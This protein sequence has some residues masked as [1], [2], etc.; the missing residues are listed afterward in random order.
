MRQGQAGEGRVGGVWVG[1]KCGLEEEEEREEGQPGM[2]LATCLGSQ[3]GAG[4]GQH[5]EALSLE[6]KAK[7]WFLREAA[8]KKAQGS[9]GSPG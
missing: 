7:S 8:W 3:A 2:S 4:E 1:A 5:Q 9:D 6:T